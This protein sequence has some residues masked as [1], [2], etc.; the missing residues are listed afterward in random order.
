[1]E[2]LKFIKDQ[3]LITNSHLRES[4]LDYL[5]EVDRL[6]SY[7]D[8]GKLLP[9]EVSRQSEVHEK[10]KAALQQVLRFQKVNPVPPPKLIKQ[11]KY[12]LINYKYTLESW[13]S[14]AV[15]DKSSIEKAGELIEGVWNTFLDVLDEQGIREIE[16]SIEALTSKIEVVEQ[17]RVSLAA[18]IQDLGMVY[19]KVMH[20]LVI[21]PAKMTTRVDEHAQITKKGI[22]EIVS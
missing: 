2:A 12:K 13:M 1:M 18:E 19:S 10:A 15:V 16:E 20:F 8:Q 5:N 4:L 3:A 7:Q 11:G 9:S 21:S 6:R 22:K 17:E 14:E